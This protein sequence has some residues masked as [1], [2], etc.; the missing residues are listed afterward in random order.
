MARECDTWKWLLSPLFTRSFPPSNG[1][2]NRSETGTGN[3][4]CVQSMDQVQKQEEKFVWCQK[5]CSTDISA[6]E[7]IFS[8][9]VC[10]CVCVLERQVSMTEVESYVFDVHDHQLDCFVLVS[11][12]QE[13]P[14]L[15]TFLVICAGHQSS[16]NTIGSL[17]QKY[18][19]SSFSMKMVLNCI[20]IWFVDL[21]LI[22]D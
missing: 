6:R 9:D 10:V 20:H 3:K 5:R 4:N 18:V 16:A 12:F 13:Q 17:F 21:F 14:T 2:G 8:G 22:K 7:F 15:P 11:T 19:S 1:T